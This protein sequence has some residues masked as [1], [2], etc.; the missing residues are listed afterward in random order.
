ME[1]NNFT[2]DLDKIGSTTENM[3]LYVNG[4]TGN[5]TTGNGAVS[6][7]FAT[8]TKAYEAVPNLIKHRVRILIAATGTYT[9]DFPELIDNRFEGSGSLAFIG[10][11][12]PSV[13]TAGPYTLASVA[14]LGTLAGTHFNVSSAGWST[15]Q[16]YGKFVRMLTGSRQNYTYS[17]LGNNADNIW[18]AQHTAKP[19]GTDTFDIVKPAVTVTLDRLTIV[20]SNQ[21]ERWNASW[22][23]ARLAL[24]NLNLDFSGS[25]TASGQLAIVNPGYIWVSFVRVVV[26]SGVY[27]PCVLKGGPTIN[28]YAPVDDGLLAASGSSVVN[29]TNTEP[30]GFIIERTGGPPGGGY[31]DLGIWNGSPNIYAYTGRGDIL[32]YDTGCR[33]SL[34]AC[35]RLMPVSSNITAANM[36]IYGKTGSIGFSSHASTSALFNNVHVLT[37]TSGFRISNANLTLSACSIDS[38][39]TGYGLEVHALGNVALDGANNLT[40][41]AGDIIW[42]APNPDTTASLPAD[43]TSVTDGLGAFVTRSD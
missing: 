4:S 41:V 21:T 42:K 5:D 36:L 24:I 43:G 3:T 18:G 1:F 35:G 26:S 34:C 22:E 16:H 32:V 39:L 27:E 7:P 14:T 9:N 2:L 19:S 38:S 28:Y 13:V 8:I 29:L 15:D 25:S 23:N 12:A 11:G 37:G 20:C 30:T 10:V 17:I 40:G 33:L 31:G 6:A